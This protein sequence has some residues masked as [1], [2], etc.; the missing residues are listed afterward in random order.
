MT[1][2]WMAVVVAAVAGTLCATANIVAGP[3]YGGTVPDIVN[4]VSVSV[5]SGAV[6][7]A[8]VAALH[9]RLDDR[10][11]ALTEFLIARL[12]ELDARSGDR[13]AGFVEGYL[14]QHRNDPAVVPIGQRL[15]GRRS[16]LG[17]DE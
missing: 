9:D 14:L 1:L 15:A 16:T 3:F 10:M 7:L 12:N 6:V 8:V 13:N 2:K 5:A 11:T 4:L 17:G